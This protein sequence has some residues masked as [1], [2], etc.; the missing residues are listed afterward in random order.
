MQ[1]EHPYE[2]TIRIE[3]RRESYQIL[4]MPLAFAFIYFRH[5][6]KHKNQAQNTKLQ[7]LPM[8]AVY[9]TEAIIGSVQM[10]NVDLINATI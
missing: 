7:H 2:Q 10:Q 1:Q 9:S 8:A 6:L 4:I 3:N 5:T